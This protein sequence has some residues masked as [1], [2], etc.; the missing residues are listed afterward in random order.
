VIEAV[1]ASAAVPIIFQPLMKDDSFYC[2]GALINNFPLH[3][4]IN[5]NNEYVDSIFS[6]DLCGIQSNVN[7][8]NNINKNSTLFE[9]AFHV[10]SNFLL[11]IKNE[12]SNYN[13]KNKITIQKHNITINDLFLSF[14]NH[15]KRQLLI[16][17]GIDQM[18]DFLK[19]L[20]EY[21]IEP[22]DIE[23]NV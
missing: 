1:Y 7:N 17:L 5:N 3:N 11:N 10:V 13:I 21:E 20:P 8:M 14:T 2:D 18:D 22:Q 6:I 19:L 23:D 4:C 12:N 15:E 9:Y 16:Q